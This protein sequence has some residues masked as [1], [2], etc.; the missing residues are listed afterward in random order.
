[1][2]LSQGSH[3][4]QALLRMQTG[5]YKDASKIPPHSAHHQLI[6][7]SAIASAG[8]RAFLQNALDQCQK[9]DAFIAGMSGMIP[10]QLSFSVQNGSRIGCSNLSASIIM[11]KQPWH[12]STGMVTWTAAAGLPRVKMVKGR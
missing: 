4:L 2:E 7:A 10:G 11:S 12:A 9:N 3:L 5:E 1:M 6:C 8:A